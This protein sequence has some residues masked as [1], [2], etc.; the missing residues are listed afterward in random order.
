MG[1]EAAVLGDQAPAVL[2]GGGVDEA[3]GRVTRERVPEGG[4]GPGDD[5]VIGIVRMS[6]ESSASQESTG[7]ET[8]IRPLRASQAS[9]NQVIPHTAR[10]SAASA[11]AA[12]SLSRSARRSTTARRGCR[13]EPSRLDVPREA[14]GEDLFLVG[15]GADLAG[16]P[17]P[18]RTAPL[19]RDEPSDHSPVLGDL[20]L[21]ARSDLVEQAEDRRL[22]LRG[23]QNSGH[24]VILVTIP[25]PV[26]RAPKHASQ[27]PGATVSVT[28]G[29]SL[30]GNLGWA[31]AL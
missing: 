13:P 30:P 26:V 11:S 19:G 24:V 23:G 1:R 28:T 21:L 14:G 31:L 6:A 15:H 27:Q 8:T 10:A 2:Q 17:A 16:E 5:Q 29:D 12:A 20:D 22:R 9:S 4:R 18:Q 25:R 7:R 3:I